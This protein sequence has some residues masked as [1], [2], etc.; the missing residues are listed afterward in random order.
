[1]VHPLKPPYGPEVPLE[2]TYTPKDP[3]SSSPNLQMLRSVPL[4]DQWIEDMLSPSAL[5]TL[6]NPTIEQMFNRLNPGGYTLNGPR[7][8]LSAPI[9]GGLQPVRPD[10][11]GNLNIDL[12]DLTGSFYRG[13][14]QAFGVIDPGAE[15]PGG[16]DPG[17]FLMERDIN[18]FGLDETGAPARLADYAVPTNWVPIVLARKALGDRLEPNKPQAT[19]E[20][21]SFQ[22]DPL[23]WSYL[24]RV[25]TVDPG[26]RDVALHDLALSLAKDNVDDSFVESFTQT[27][28]KVIRD[29]YQS[30]LSLTSGDERVDYNA[31]MEFQNARAL[32]P[33]QQQALLGP[34]STEQV[35]ALLQARTPAL[36]P[37]TINTGS[38]ASEV[39]TW[40]SML[41]FIGTPAAQ[42]IAPIT[43]ETEQAWQ[44]LTPAERMGYINLAQT[45]QAVTD[46]DT[47]VLG[48]GGIQTIRG[49]ALAGQLGKLGTAA[50]YGYDVAM[51]AANLTMAT[52]LIN[53]GLN[54]ALEAYSPYY[55]EN[56]GRYI[57]ASRPV[58]SSQLAGFANV[59][60][61]F[62]SGTYGAA[63]AVRILRRVAGVSLDV[64]ARVPFVGRV[65]PRP[66]FGVKEN[67][68]FATVNGG[69]RALRGIKEMTNGTATDE[70][71]RMTVRSELLSSLENH[72]Q[73]LVIVHEDALAAALIDLDSTHPLAMLYH[74]DPAAWR[75][76]V[77][78]NLMQRAE[79]VPAVTAQIL[80]FISA[81]SR[82]LSPWALQGTEAA[83][84][85]V[86][87]IVQTLF[88]GATQYNLQR[89]GTW[90]EHLLDPAAAQAEARRLF[91]QGGFQINEG[92]LAR[93]GTKR[94]GG[95][96]LAKQQ[97]ATIRQMVYHTK[98]SSM[99]EVARAAGEDSTELAV[100]SLRHL[101]EDEIDLIAAILRGE[102]VDPAVLATARHPVVLEGENNLKQWIQSRTMLPEGAYTASISHKDLADLLLEIKD[103]L[104]ARRALSEGAS[105]PLDTFQRQLEAGQDWTVIRKPRRFPESDPNT[106]STLLERQVTGSPRA[107]SDFASV[108]RLRDGSL[109]KSPWIEYPLGSTDMIELG[110]RGTLGHLISSATNGTRAWR[111]SEFQRANLHRLLNTRYSGLTEQQL[112]NLHRE[113]QRMARD[114]VRIVRVQGELVQ[115]KPDIKFHAVL[116]M[117]G[118][119]WKPEAAE[120]ANRI[121]GGTDLSPAML[122]NRKTG[123]WEVP[124]W[125]NLLAKA[126]TQSMKLNLTAG[127]TSRLK[128][129][130]Y[131]GEWVVK[132]SEQLYT[133]WRFGLSP[134]FKASEYVESGGFNLMRGVYWDDPYTRDMIIRATGH[135]I[136]SQI[137]ENL[138]VGDT[139]IQGMASSF[140]K[141]SAR[142]GSPRVA[143]FMSS[144][145][146]AK[147]IRAR[148]MP[149]GR[150]STA[151]TDSQ[152]LRR[153]ILNPTPERQLSGDYT[154]ATPNEMIPDAQVRNGQREMRPLV[155]GLFNRVFRGRTLDE[156]NA[157]GRVDNYLGRIAHESVPLMPQP[158]RMQ[159]TARQPN[160]T[161]MVALHPDAYDNIIP[162]LGDLTSTPPSRVPVLSEADRS[163][164]HARWQATRGR[165][166][167]PV[168]VNQ[169]ADE[170][171]S[172]RLGE[173]ADRPPD[174][175]AWARD[176]RWPRWRTIIEERIDS[177]GI[178]ERGGTHI[179]IPPEGRAFQDLPDTYSGQPLTPEAVAQVRQIEMQ[180]AVLDAS[181]G[182]TM[183]DVIDRA[184]TGSQVRLTSRVTDHQWTDVDAVFLT[185]QENVA[186]VRFMRRAAEDHPARGVEIRFYDG[187]QSGLNRAYA[188]WAMERAGLPDMGSRTIGSLG[189]LE[190]PAEHAARAVDW[191]IRGEAGFIDAV[192]AS[193]AQKLGYD[194]GVPMIRTYLRRSPATQIDE[195]VVTVAAADGRSL[196][197]TPPEIEQLWREHGAPA[198]FASSLTDDAATFLRNQEPPTAVA[199][200]TDGGNGRIF[201][202][203]DVQNRPIT[204]TISEADDG[205][206]VWSDTER[207]GIPVTFASRFVGVRDYQP[208]TDLYPRFENGRVIPTG[209]RVHYAPHNE[210]GWT[211]RVDRITDSGVT[212]HLDDAA[213]YGY[214]YE[215]Q[216]RDVIVR[217]DKQTTLV[218]LPNEAAADAYMRL[219]I[220][221]E[222]PDTMAANA[223]ATIARQRPR[224][225]APRP[226]QPDN[227]VLRL[228]TQGAWAT[229]DEVARMADESFF[230]D[231]TDFGRGR[232]GI[233]EMTVGPQGDRHALVARD[234]H[235]DVEGFLSWGDAPGDRVGGIMVKVHPERRRQ[236][237]ATR[238]YDEA[239]ARG[240]PIRPASG[241]MTTADGQAFTAAY[242]LR[243]DEQAGM[244]PFDL[245]AMRTRYGVPEAVANDVPRA[246][247]DMSDIVGSDA[248]ILDEMASLVERTPPLPAKARGWIDKFADL[249]NPI[250]WKEGQMARQQAFL[251]NNTF[252]PILKRA[253]PA[254]YSLLTDT[255]KVPPTQVTRFMLEGKALEQRWIRTGLNE[256]LDTLIAHAGKYTRIEGEASSEALRALYASDDWQAVSALWLINARTASQEAFTTHFFSSYRSALERS[257]NHPILG[258]YPLSWAYKAAR[259]WI[260]FLFE[261]RMLGINIHMV[262]AVA[263]KKIQEQEDKAWAL[264]MG[265]NESFGETISTER[266]AR[267][268]AFFYISN[269]LLPGDWSSLPFPLAAPIRDVVRW[270]AGQ[271]NAA[272]PLATLGGLTTALDSWG[273]SRDVRL[274]QEAAQELQNWLEG[275]QPRISNATSNPA[276]SSQIHYQ[277]EQQHKITPR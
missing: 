37:G 50:A 194:P 38:F 110:N 133:M 132:A 185:Q 235:G 19:Q 81:N 121:F 229:S 61:Y 40:A 152:N 34:P 253:N 80:D 6:G 57:D 153:G 213:E 221:G 144:A 224:G 59:L 12:L 240:I 72:I 180:Q 134:I 62:G 66:I 252:A 103:Q 122:L 10:K 142:A 272:S 225:A 88:D 140:H 150:T 200:Q 131:F 236:G 101:Y 191:M 20:F 30:I 184:M 163:V 114:P 202:Y 162:T 228:S 43:A 52:G 208:L 33:A 22:G 60:G 95:M 161:G 148:Q 149:G 214:Q 83:H 265:S 255:L 275:P 164:I 141:T 260:L 206:R 277:E 205:T 76:A 92:K 42:F 84:A 65:L 123:Q 90:Y 127:A 146:E 231:I 18:L 41:P 183:L 26:R 136:D 106:P 63:Q 211:Y 29:D 250:P 177:L 48:F 13:T 25:D 128:A 91:Q 155:R 55:A 47:I 268:S 58:S 262:P 27:L 94:G 145:D 212:V 68:F 269:L 97:L 120:A 186:W 71:M 69:A 109:Y 263:I 227:G 242:W 28:E 182:D 16:F 93:M 8:D 215:E 75:R 179:D 36:L 220:R 230:R 85:Q 193:A 198:T 102:E 143:A 246:I 108:R 178:A 239:R 257:L 168:A 98:L 118:W 258:I 181:P 14:L 17:A 39:A 264:Y 172:Y 248:A 64:A 210:P 158:M 243:V 274:T 195:M 3:L 135:Q 15:L 116:S 270:A 196:R 24:N 245:A 273:I 238:L 49:I 138:G 251:V 113:I 207:A 44:N 137:L 157:V 51:K 5:G 192:R 254:V 159:A 4:S 201:V 45:H 197:L 82:E 232:P 96:T 267:Y 74:S 147:L 23:Y 165:R 117:Q 271:P 266:R 217:F 175:G 115:V 241:G 73:E 53:A 259:E 104:P 219:W 125:N 237:I 247:G 256:D 190:Y 89:Y 21:Y 32:P 276:I 167:R 166:G 244:V 234:A 170:Y 126:Y 79:S 107:A 171:L 218:N 129:M 7:P 77:S 154:G 1:M 169:W 203:R 130:P 176:P 139:L 174:P 86:K 70:M 78:I 2:P 199:F 99:L 173:R 156:V 222:L 204:A 124:E 112:N 87:K 105:S 100:G 160:A 249:W 188:T 187:T 35:G 223:P 151:F 261:N 233:S 11:L 54:W 31:K 9:L 56:E 67:P 216:L 111:I 189:L 226:W 119:A 46:M 209:N